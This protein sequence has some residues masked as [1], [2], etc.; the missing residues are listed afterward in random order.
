M[1]THELANEE[2]DL[3]V[4]R[5]IQKHLNNPNAPEDISQLWLDLKRELI[6]LVVAFTSQKDRKEKR[7]LAKLLKRL[8]G[9]KDCKPPSTHQAHHL[10]AIELRLNKALRKLEASSKER[11]AASLNRVAQLDLEEL[12]YTS[13]RTAQRKLNGADRNIAALRHPTTR[14]LHTDT[15]SNL[16][17]ARTFYETLF[18]SEQNKTEDDANSREAQAFLSTLPLAKLTPEQKA[19]LTRPASEEEVL[20]FFVFFKSFY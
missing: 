4:H 6:A 18:A 11:R 17:V 1:P 8:R 13:Y 14:T 16:D 7:Q 19:E 9:V 12:T 10:F 5:L 15:L 2:L 3:E 20:L